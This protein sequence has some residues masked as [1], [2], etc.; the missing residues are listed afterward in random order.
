MVT[1]EE[2]IKEELRCPEC[3]QDILADME[4]CPNCGYK[5]IKKKKYYFFLVVI[6][7]VCFIGV[8]SYFTYSHIQN[9]IKI[10]E[11]QRKKEV[12]NIRLQMSDAYNDADLE[13]VAKCLDSLSSL[14]EDVS[15]EQVDLDFDRENIDIVMKFYTT[16][17]EVDSSLESSDYSS[18]SSLVNKMKPVMDDLNKIEIKG[19][20]K[21][22]QYIRNETSN[23]MYT[24]FYN[25]YIKSK[26]YDLDYGLT[27]GG[28]AMIIETYTDEMMKV[29]YPFND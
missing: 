26:N 28:Y 6:A 1:S 5:L 25:Q 22:A 13:T 23:I 2:N 18:L 14:G 20:S 11:E 15:S 10:E 3:N 8:G 19:N 12:K 7:M 4:T 16:L 24:T 9:R 17:K 21:L 29:D 27:S